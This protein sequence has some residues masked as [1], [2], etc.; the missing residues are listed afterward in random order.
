MFDRHGWQVTGSGGLV[1]Y[2]SA[3]LRD[4]L[5]RVVAGLISM[6][7][8][9]RGQP[10][11]G[12]GRMQAAENLT[13]PGQH[14]VADWY[15]DPLSPEQAG[16]L[17]S[18]SRV[19]LR[20]AYVESHSCF[21]AHLLALIGRFWQ[22]R[23]IRPDYL[24]L[25][26]AAETDTDHALLKLVYGQLL[27]S[28][29]LKGAN[30]HLSSGFYLAAPLLLPRDYFRMVK[31]HDLLCYLPLSDEP[32]EPGDLRTLLSEA[33]VIRRLR[34]RRIFNDDAGMRLDTIG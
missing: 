16:R 24:S 32:S 14:K 9:G 6:S 25:V 21:S 29:K 31:R 3:A 22:G 20:M 11:D 7:W 5:V 12:T 8:Y 17:L 26:A 19:K 33:A 10:L 1:R 4:T 34:S 13:I 27:M 18:L 30:C 28:R 2:V 23:D 15:G